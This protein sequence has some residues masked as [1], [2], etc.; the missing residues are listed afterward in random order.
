MSH[1]FHVVTGGPGAGKTTVLGLLA[2]RGYAVMD[3]AGR[4]IIRHRAIT[5]G[6]PPWQDPLLFAEL[7]FSW[8][9]R[10]LDLAA[11]RGGPV[12]FDRGI[13]D[14]IAYLRLCGLPVPDHMLRA[15]RQVRYAGMVF[16]MPWWPEIYETDAERLQTPE[17]ARQTADIVAGTWRE[18]GYELV[19]VPRDGPDARGDFIAT[20]I[21]A[22]R[23]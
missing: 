14:T 5:G 7:M 17:V 9:M 18:L 22:A 11:Q 19:E 13:P 1:H 8:E 6:P 21:G 23:R 4:G 3:E 16:L 12:L 15:A 2:G 20:H 10:S